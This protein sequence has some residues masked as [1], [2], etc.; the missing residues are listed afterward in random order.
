MGTQTA[1][2]NYDTAI[3]Y[4]PEERVTGFEQF[5]F[6]VQALISGDVDAVIIDGV[7]GLGQLGAFPARLRHER[8]AVES[9]QLD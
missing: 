5:P 2:T 7:A 1:T 8:A 6:A 9:R 4:L 3:E